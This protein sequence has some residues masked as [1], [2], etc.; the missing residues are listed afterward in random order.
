MAA[1]AREIDEPQPCRIAVKVLR[2]SITMTDATD[3]EFAT[4]DLVSLPGTGEEGDVIDVLPFHGGLEGSMD[5]ALFVVAVV[6]WKRTGK[7]TVVRAA[8][9]IKLN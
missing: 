6:R 4:G 2:W 1:S 9:L 8:D 7:K 3:H 5:R